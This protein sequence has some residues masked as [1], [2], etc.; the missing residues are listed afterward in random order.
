MGACAGAHGLGAYCF[1]SSGPEWR[2]GAGALDSKSVRSLLFHG[3]G[4][5]HTCQGLLEPK[6]MAEGLLWG[7]AFT[8]SCLQLELCGLCVG[9]GGGGSLFLASGL[10]LRSW[11]RGDMGPRAI[12]RQWWCFGAPSM[13]GQ[14]LLL[15]AGAGDPPPPSNCHPWAPFPELALHHLLVCCVVWS[16]GTEDPW[17]SSEHKPGLRGTQTSAAAGPVA[18]CR[19]WPWFGDC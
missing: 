2:A 16:G 14:R 4:A 9:G 1:L 7:V 12:T 3:G 13:P 19:L 6:A 10:G 11:H 5:P 15:G 17:N 18:R 8:V